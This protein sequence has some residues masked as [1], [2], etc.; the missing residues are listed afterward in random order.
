MSDEVEGA[1][2]ERSMSDE[3]GEAKRA[4]RPALMAVRR[5][6]PPE[7][8]EAAG[9]AA[10][11]ELLSLPALRAAGRVALYAALADE[12][13]TRPA[14]EALAAL[15]CRRLLPRIVGDTLEFAAVDAWSELVPGSYGVLAPPPAA[16]AE[17]LTAADVVLVPGVAFGPAGERLG[18]GGGYY[19]RA[20]AQAGPLRVG[21]AYQSQLVERVPVDSHDRP[22]DAIV[23]EQGV[24]WPPGN[25]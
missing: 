9:R 5:A 21:F 20:L 10:A 15:S 23:T 11:R 7:T 14:F 19:D 8:R 4:L 18:R 13:P 3:V 1:T 24:I 16:L 2:R 12:L 22:M 6:I 25:S 17:A